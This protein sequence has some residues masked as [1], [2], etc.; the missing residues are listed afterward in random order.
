MKKILL[1][2]AVSLLGVAASAQKFAHVNF[3]ELVQLM[4]EADGA[5]AT[6]Q[7]SQKNAQETY[8][9]MMS[10]FQ[11]KYSKYQQGVNNLTPATRKAKED[12]LTQIQQRIQEFG[13]NVEQE[14]QEQQQ[15]LM[16]PIYKKAQ[17]TVNT[18]A[19][20]RGFIYVF[21]RSSVLFIDETQ[22]VDITSDARKA[23]GIP[24]E[25]TLETLQAELAAQAQTQAA[26]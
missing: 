12:E 20:E 15:K 23:L 26:Q 19:K 4:P 14:L 2:A 11:D 10:E 16:E 9:A 17:E 21:D 6:M 8:Q 1:I 24:A 3:Q 22:S 18:L 7:E 5:R 13:Q 25:R